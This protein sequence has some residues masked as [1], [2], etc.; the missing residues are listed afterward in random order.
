MM[1]SLYASLV[2]PPQAM[3]GSLRT[4]CRDL[5]NAENL[6]IGED[7]RLFVTTREG[8]YELLGGSGGVCEKKLIPVRVNDLP[9]SFMKNGI[10]A[11][12]HYLYLACAHVHQ[13]DN[14]LLKAIMDDVNNVE[15]TS[16]GLLQI[17]LAAFTFHAESWIVRCDLRKTPAAFTDVL[18]SLPD[19]VLANGIA[20]D[21]QRRCL[22]VANSGPSLTPGI[23][24]VPLEAAGVSVQDIPWCRLPDCKPNGLKILDD[25]LYYTGNGI[26][27]AVFGSVKINH[28]GSASEPQ[29]ID[30]AALQVF[31]DFEAVKQG[32]L[33][34]EFGD[35]LGLQA[36]SLRFVSKRGRQL[37]VLQHPDLSKPCAVAVARQNGELVAAGDILIVN[38]NQGRVMVFTPDEPWRDSL[39]ASPG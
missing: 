21:T 27:A 11:H 31:D 18:G 36:G 34:A 9:N 14:P 24:R 6:V 15:Q 28:D 29:V 13:S 7:Q 20:I 33:I 37:G 22:Y 3:S 17:Y 39:A 19:N 32:F 4:L 1:M 2:S 26:P 35:H 12:G 25:T 5:S 8:V 10:V 23:Y 16:M 30:T 38:K